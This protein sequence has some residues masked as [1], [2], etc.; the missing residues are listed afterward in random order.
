MCGVWVFTLD[1]YLVNVWCWVGFFD[2]VSLGVFGVSGGVLCFLGEGV[3]VCLCFGLCLLFVGWWCGLL[4]CFGFV[5][6][7]SGL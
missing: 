2:C 4:L 6:D 7:L 5:G 3:W 1:C